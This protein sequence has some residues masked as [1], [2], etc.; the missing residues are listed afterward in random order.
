MRT[1]RYT[2]SPPVASHLDDDDMKYEN[3]LASCV[4]PLASFSPGA[5]R[6]R[7][8]PYLLLGDAAYS[9]RKNIAACARVGMVPGIMH[10][11]NVTARGKG[12]GDAWGVSVRNQMGGSPEA[13]H[14]N[15]M[16]REEKRENQAYWKARIGYG[17]RWLV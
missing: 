6:N 11:I 13:T 16:S 4:S 17:T 10:T 3:L 7:T 1:T 8:A 9:S 15:L 2:V 12:S 14:L 5:P